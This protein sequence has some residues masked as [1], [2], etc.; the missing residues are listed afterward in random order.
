VP[1]ASR[2]ITR[3]YG[4]PSRCLTGQSLTTDHPHRQGAGKE[5]P[6]G[7]AYPNLIR[8]DDALRSRCRQDVQ[9]TSGKSK[10]RM[11]HGWNAGP[12]PCVCVENTLHCRRTHP[13]DHAPSRRRHHRGATRS[14]VPHGEERRASEGESG[15]VVQ[16]VGHK[17]VTRDMGIPARG[18]PLLTVSQTC[19]IPGQRLTRVRLEV[20]G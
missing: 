4:S 17:G 5:A 20:P 18:L 6:A 8:Q 7:H 16:R 1:N 2:T 11:D 15:A 14:H 12:R 19:R 3:C 10:Q 13:R 9:S